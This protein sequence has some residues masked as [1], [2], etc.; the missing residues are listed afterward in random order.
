MMPVVRCGES[1]H[2]CTDLRQDLLGHTTTYP[3]DL[4]KAYE[5]VFLLKPE[6]T[7]GHRW[8]A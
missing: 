4:A 5:R 3:W 7:E 6:S 2:V 1:T 8:T